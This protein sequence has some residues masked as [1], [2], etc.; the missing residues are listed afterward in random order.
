MKSINLHEIIKQIPLESISSFAQKIGLGYVFSAT[1][2]DILIIG[3][4]HCFDVILASKILKAQGKP[5]LVYGIDIFDPNWHPEKETLAYLRGIDFE[6]A[7]KICLEYGE[8]NIVLLQGESQV[9]GKILEKNFGVVY[10]DG[11]HAYE[12]VK[13]DFEFFSSQIIPNGFLCFHDYSDSFLGVK[14]LVEEIKSDLRHLWLYESRI[15]SLVIF[16]R[17]PNER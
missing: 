12:D 15:G 6:T 9:V 8:N 16:R 5:Y 10:I 11:S 13:S 1:K 2:G 3:C 4:F 7:K 17:N 14:K